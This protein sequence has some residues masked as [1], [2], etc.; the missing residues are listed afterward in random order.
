MHLPLMYRT[1]LKDSWLFLQRTSCT[2]QSFRSDTATLNTQQVNLSPEAE[3]LDKS[4][5]KS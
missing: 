4:R 2:L 5:Q 1:P 3:F